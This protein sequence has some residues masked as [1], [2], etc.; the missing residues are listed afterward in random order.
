M[1]VSIIIVHYDCVPALRRCL[2][3][4]QQHISLTDREI[5]VLDN[6]SLSSDLFK[7]LQQEFP[8]VQFHAMAQ[9]LGFGNAN[10]E[11]LRW[12]KGRFLFFLNPDTLLQSDACEAFAQWLDDP[13]HASYA[14]C[15]GQLLDEAGKPATSGGNFPGLFH[16]FSSIGF[17]RFYSRYFYRNLATGV[18]DMGAVPRDID[19]VS[20]ANLFVRRAVFEKV[21][22]FDPDFFLYFE[23]T[24]LAWRM[25]KAGW[26]MAV[27]PSVKIV[28]EEGSAGSNERT[29]FSTFRYRHYLQGRQIFYR[30]A[31]GIG[32]AVLAV[33]FDFIATLV[34]GLIK[35]EFY[36]LFAQL[37][38]WLRSGFGFKSS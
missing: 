7:T 2:A 12:A 29:A 14:A 3:S 10:N 37:Q 11:A 23:E 28:H 31:H 18:T 19:Y 1:Q 22:G 17:F 33:I 21:G 4:I 8:W 9:N 16:S 26:K 20:G 32:Y 36:L 30:K 35:G 5:F 34:R 15:G 25:R 27:L 38:V 24:E 13:A 6:A